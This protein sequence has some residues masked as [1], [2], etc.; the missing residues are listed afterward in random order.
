MADLSRIASIKVRI[1]RAKEHVGNLKSEIDAFLKGEPYLM[2][3]EDEQQTRGGL[4]A[5]RASLRRDLRPI[6]TGER[7]TLYIET[8]N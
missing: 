6:L 3:P 5:A 2:V 1:E 8:A 7:W 4:A